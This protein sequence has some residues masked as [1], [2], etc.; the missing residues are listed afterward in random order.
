MDDLSTIA[1]VPFRVS[2]ILVGIAVVIALLAIC[3]MLMFFFCQST[4]VFYL[5]AWMQV[6]SGKSSGARSRLS[7]IKESEISKF[8]RIERARSFLRVERSIRATP[9]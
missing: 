6:V 7:Y 4:T 2:T 5:C 8:S 3:A 1:N 9:M